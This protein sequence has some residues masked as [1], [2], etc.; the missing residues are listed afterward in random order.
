[1]GDPFDTEDE[2]A[3][4]IE[5]AVRP[6]WP[7]WTSEFYVDS[8]DDQSY[9]RVDRGAATGLLVKV[10]LEDGGISSSA[11]MQL[12]LCFRLYVQNCIKEGGS[13]VDAGCPTFL[14][15][16]HG[17]RTPS[18]LS[19]AYSL[20]RNL[21]G[22]RL[23]ICGAFWDGET[24]T[25]ES[26]MDGGLLMLTDYSGKRQAKLAHTLAALHKAHMEILHIAQ[27]VCYS[28]QLSRK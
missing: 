25:I 21:S 16:I 18:P 26:L 3:R 19:S 9:G 15:L 6:L 24:C 4:A 7:N 28:S 1:M 8:F 20:I 22:E 5:W 23:M 27:C 11:Y 10:N 17:M 14:L 12:C 2:R 13:F